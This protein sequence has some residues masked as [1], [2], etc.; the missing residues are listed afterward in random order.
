MNIEYRTGITISK[1]GF[2]TGKLTD[3]SFT[4]EE[5]ADCNQTIDKIF[6]SQ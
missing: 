6:N 1:Q 2:V 5:T 3:K 4:K